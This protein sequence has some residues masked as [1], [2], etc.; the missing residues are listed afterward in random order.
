M[1][2]TDEVGFKP[3]DTVRCFQNWE[4]YI[5][6]YKDMIGVIT[7]KPHPLAGDW[8]LVE[9]EGLPLKGMMKFDPDWTLI[10]PHSEDI[11]D[12]IDCE[13]RKLKR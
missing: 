12:I 10:P 1:E 6:G 2:R 4:R 8:L 11:R 5:G 9:V 7:R 3:G 13:V